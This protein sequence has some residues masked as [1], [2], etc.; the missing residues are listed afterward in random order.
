VLVVG[1][2]SLPPS[3]LWAAEGTQG[4]CKTSSGLGSVAPTV[5]LLANSVGQCKSHP[6]G[7]SSR[8]F[9]DHLSSSF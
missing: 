5:S 7:L 1:W 6:T 9:R 3:N 4:S 2:A 8:A